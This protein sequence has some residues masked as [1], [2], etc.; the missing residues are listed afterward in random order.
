MAAAGFKP[1]GPDTSLAMS[2]LGD[3]SIKNAR[4]VISYQTCS[5][6]GYFQW[7][8]FSHTDIQD[9]N[10][11]FIF[12]YF[13][14][15]NYVKLGV[16]TLYLKYLMYFVYLMYLM[17]LMYLVYLLYLCI[18]VFSLTPNECCSCQKY[19]VIDQTHT[20]KFSSFRHRA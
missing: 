7:L 6:N 15:R 3:N 16:T 10:Y 17:Y 19:G 14:R 11:R 4:L 13:F 8:L 1:L 20:G 9:V 5:F 2:L 12:N 18:F